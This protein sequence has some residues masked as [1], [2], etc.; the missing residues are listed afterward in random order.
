MV[1]TALNK[2]KEAFTITQG[3]DTECKVK[4]MALVKLVMFTGKFSLSRIT[5]PMF[6][7]PLQF[8]SLKIWKWNGT[9]EL[10]WFT[11]YFS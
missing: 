10:N 6:T 4:E 2:F 1:N 5:M 7:T 3:V 9:K 8:F 11:T